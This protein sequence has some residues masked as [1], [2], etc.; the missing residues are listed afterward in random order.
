VIVFEIVF[1]VSNLIEHGD[2]DL[3]LALERRVGRALVTPAL[4]RRH[5]SRTG[6]ER[7]SN[8]GTIFAI[9]DRL[10]GTFVDNSSAVH[11]D[12]GLPELHHTPG[13]RSALVLPR[14]V[15]GRAI[16]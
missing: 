8:Y 5:H 2:I 14:R 16:S 6:A 13:L 12:T 4:H 10:L 11:V 9:W 3:P 15:Y 1:S 7:D